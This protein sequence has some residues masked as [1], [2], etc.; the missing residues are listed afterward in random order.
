MCC[1]FGS[2]ANATTPCP[3]CDVFKPV[4]RCPHVTGVCRN[5]VNHPRMDVVYLKNAEVQCFNGCGYCK[6]SAVNQR[7]TPPAQ[8]PGWPGCCRPPIGPTECAMIQAADW[9]SVSLVHHIPI[10]P[11]IKFV[12]DTV[13][14]KQTQLSGS[15]GRSSASEFAQAAST[16]AGAGGS[17]S[18]SKGSPKL[19]SPSAPVTGRPRQGS[20]LGPFPVTGPSTSNTATSISSN[21][22]HQ[23]RR[24]SDADKRSHGA[25]HSSPN[26][27]QHDLDS[28]T[29]R[30]KPASRPSVPGSRS[31]NIE[32]QHS[33]LLK[34]GASTS[35]NSPPGSKSGSSPSRS[36]VIPIAP[37]TPPI[38]KNNISSS[39]SSSSSGSSDGLGS[40]TDST[41]TSDG[42]FTDYLSSGSEEELQ[43]QAEAKAA[44]V[45]QTQAEELEFKAARQQLQSVDLRPPKSWVLSNSNGQ[46]AGSHYPNSNGPAFVAAP[47]RG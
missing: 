23:T 4:G 33:N 26:S 29:P 10:P 12:L 22:Y 32:P 14:P 44:L 16:R 5:R 6:W 31:P 19:S 21:D 1:S 15:L 36:P 38:R 30:R 43:R 40:S 39:A 13:S 2:L 9:P 18:S 45:A 25:T 20:V 17:V 37:R 35:S 3:I 47:A 7:S 27:K 24:Q 8:N 34:R 42:G 28:T 46:R 11:E 41:L